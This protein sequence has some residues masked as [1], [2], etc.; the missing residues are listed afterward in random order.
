[1]RVVFLVFS[2]IVALTVQSVA[3]PRLEV[4]GAR[5]DWLLILV[6]FFAMHASGREAIV[7]GFCV[8]LAADLLTLERPGLL[9]LS[10][11]LVAAFVASI[12]EY[13]FVGRMTTLLA[14]T[15]VCG[16][17][18]Q[19]S[20]LIYR[21]VLYN[22]YA[23]GWEDVVISVLLVP[24][25]SAAWAALVHFLLMPAARFCGFARIPKKRFRL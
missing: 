13:L 6:T 18:L 19:T 23:A 12:R 3:G 14:L 22:A 25:Y 11:L 8:G 2:A 17:G 24:A 21:R 20:W 7:A 9:S 5:P 16:L 10:Y 1:M 4:F 15:F